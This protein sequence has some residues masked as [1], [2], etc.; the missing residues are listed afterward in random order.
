M[1]LAQDIVSD[2]LLREL[3]QFEQLIRPLTAVQWDATSRCEGWTVGDVA[4]HV[5]GDMADV[6][7]GRL[8]GLGSPEVTAREV[9]ERAGRT[10]IELADEWAEVRKAIAGILPLFDAAAWAGPAGAG[11]DGTLGDGIETL[12]FDTFLHGDDVRAALGRTSELG[13]G[14]AASVS[15]VSSELA[16]RGWTGTVPT[17]DGWALEFVLA[18]TGR[19]EAAI[20]GA[21]APINLYA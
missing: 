5:V 18:A 8:E 1:A 14:L 19:A 4:G 21:D 13:P 10:P 20:L 7:A 2:G 11:Y 16:K 6:V 9:A 3:E 17:D 15:H 12:W